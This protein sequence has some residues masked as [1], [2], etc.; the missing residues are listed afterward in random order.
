[1]GIFYSTQDAKVWYMRFKANNTGQFHDLI[2]NNNEILANTEKGLFYSNQDAKV[3][4]K[5]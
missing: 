2:L 1:M 5:K 3:W 4:Y